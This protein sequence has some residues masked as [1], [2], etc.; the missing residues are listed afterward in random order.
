MSLYTCVDNA[1]H[2]HWQEFAL[3]GHFGYFNLEGKA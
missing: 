2:V 3:M 1:S